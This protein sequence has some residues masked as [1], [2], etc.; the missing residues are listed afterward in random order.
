MLEFDT[1]ERLLSESMKLS[2]MANSESGTGSAAVLLAR[3][4]SLKGDKRR[5]AKLL[6]KAILML[7]SLDPSEY[8]LRL[9]AKFP[10]L[11]ELE[12]ELARLQM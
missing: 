2:Q 6:R 12:T 8:S 10:A 5:A 7:Q 1:A 4:I 3:T 9:P 11:S